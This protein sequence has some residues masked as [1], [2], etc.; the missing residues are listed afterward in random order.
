MAKKE[1]LFVQAAQSLS[2][3]LEAQSAVHRCFTAFDV[4][5]ASDRRIG[6]RVVVNPPEILAATVHA[7]RAALVGLKV[8]PK[9]VVAILHE[10]CSRYS[11][12]RAPGTA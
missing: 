6:I 1:E 5:D 10:A 12:R 11:S 4:G 9:P 3:R 7:D 8:G 2:I